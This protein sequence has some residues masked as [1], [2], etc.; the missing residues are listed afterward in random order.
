MKTNVFHLC[1]SVAFC[2]LFLNVCKSE[3][4]TED[5][6]KTE[7][8]EEPL[9]STLDIIVLSLAGKKN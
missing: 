1:L 2:L 4:T 8:E 6:A 7:E 3:T 5:E 9:F